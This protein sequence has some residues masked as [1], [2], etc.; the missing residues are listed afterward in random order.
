VILLRAS[1]PRREGGESEK[2]ILRRMEGEG[3]LAV[4]RLN[5]IRLRRGKG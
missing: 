4:K 1:L 5:L 3:N 2:R